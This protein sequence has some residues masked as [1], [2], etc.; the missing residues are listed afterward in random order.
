M[1][2]VLPISNSADLRRAASTGKIRSEASTTHL[3]AKIPSEADTDRHRNPQLLYSPADPRD[4]A[5]LA[6]E[7]PHLRARSPAAA[8]CEIGLRVNRAMW[9]GRERA[10]GRHLVGAAPVDA[11]AGEGVHVL[12]LRARRSLF[13]LWRRAAAAAGEGGFLFCSDFRPAR[14]AVPLV[15][16]HC[17]I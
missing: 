16:G 9:G 2:L 6:L 10:G 5:D 1:T 11:E 3:S 13:V 15:P 14:A 8:P 7:L 17:W 12:H 4:D